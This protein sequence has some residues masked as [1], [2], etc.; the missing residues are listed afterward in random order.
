MVKFELK[1]V[2]QIGT[3]VGFWPKKV[4]YAET[5]KAIVCQTAPLAK[6]THGGFLFIHEI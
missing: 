1:I 2:D 5:F 3:S 4:K 6:L